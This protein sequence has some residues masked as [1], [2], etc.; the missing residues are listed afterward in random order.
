MIQRPTT[1]SQQANTLPAPGRTGVQLTGFNAAGFPSQVP[2]NTPLPAQP[3]YQV[4]ST[5][6]TS[7]NVSPQP[8]SRDFIEK[9][10]PVKKLSKRAGLTLSPEE[11]SENPNQKRA[12][13]FMEEF[14]TMPWNFKNL[15]DPYGQH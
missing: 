12:K 13:V 4:R 6:P 5:G 14:A 15:F 2:G 11:I 7:G 1:P 8:L 3:G 9:R 10:L